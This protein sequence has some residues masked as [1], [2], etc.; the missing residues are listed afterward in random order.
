MTSKELKQLRRS[1]LLEMLLELSRE[2]ETLREENQNL[3]QLL[4]DRN[5]AI[6]NSG[7]LAEAVLQL[8]GVFEAAQEACRQYTDNIRARSE[9]IEKHCREMEEETR[10][11]C[12][13]MLADAQEEAHHSAKTPEYPEKESKIDYSWLEKLLKSGETL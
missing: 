12:E 1:D 9:N 5:I 7:S 3:K 13:K 8:N 11:K 4:D 2:N 10:E 6:R